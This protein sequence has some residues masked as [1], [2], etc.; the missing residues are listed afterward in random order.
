MVDVTRSYG[1]DQKCM[2]K[3]NCR[4]LHILTGKRF[5]LKNEK[6]CIVYI[7]CEIYAVKYM[8]CLIYGRVLL[9]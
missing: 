3:V 8:L 7:F 6:E 1:K 2:E 5:L 4:Y 9:S